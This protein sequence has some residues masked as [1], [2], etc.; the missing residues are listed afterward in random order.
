[1]TNHQEE[2]KGREGKG[3]EGKG[4]VASGRCGCMLLI[5][6]LRRLKQVALEESLV[7]TVSCR[8]ARAT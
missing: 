6:T 8:P 4:N 7:N 3:R 2:G 1:V 5:T